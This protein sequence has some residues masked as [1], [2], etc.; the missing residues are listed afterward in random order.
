MSQVNQAVGVI[1]RKVWGS[2]MLE[3]KNP[4]TEWW[5]CEIKAEEDKKEAIWKITIGSKKKTG[6]EKYMKIY[7]EEKR[8]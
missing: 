8:S 7:E 4:N 6:K 2:A 5:N 1:A 3:R